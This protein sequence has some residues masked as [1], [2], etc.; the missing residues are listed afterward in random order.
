MSNNIVM[1]AL[2]CDTGYIKVE[3]E[4]IKIVDMNKASVYGDWDGLNA[5]VVTT[6]LPDNVIIVELTI[7]EREIGPFHR[8]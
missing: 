7:T 8:Q 6:A 5:A 3:G 2:K 4:A 1:Y